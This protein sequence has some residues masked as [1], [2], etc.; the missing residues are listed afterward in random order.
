MNAYR[1][2]V[3]IRPTW[4]DKLKCWWNHD[5]ELISTESNYIYSKYSYQCNRC[6][7]LD[8]YMD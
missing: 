8:Y 3:E 7:S 4:L 6:R 1:N 2:N 5:W